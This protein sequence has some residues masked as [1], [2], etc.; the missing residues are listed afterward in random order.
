MHSRQLPHMLLLLIACSPLLYN[1]AAGE[2]D[3]LRHAQAPT[4]SPLYEHL[5]GQ[6]HEA[7]DRRLEEYESVE[8]A[9]DAAAYQ[10]KR[11]QFF[12]RQLG[13]FPQRTPLNPQVVGRFASNGYRVEKVIFESQPQHHVT[14]VMYLPEAAGLYPCVVVAS[15]HSR[16][17][18]AADYNQRF[19]IIM[20][21]NGMAALCYDPIGQGERSQILDDSGQPKHRSTTA[22]HFQIGVGSILLGTNTARYRVWDAM[23]A[24]DYAISRDD[25]DGQRIG[26]TGCSG[27]GTLTSYVMALDDRV[28]CAAPA[29]YLTTF[30]RLIDT[31][32]PQDAE[33]NIFGQIAFGMD[34]PDYVI[35]RAPRPTIISATTGDYFD[36]QGVW[37]NYRQ[38]KRF[39]MRLGHPERVDIVEG[40]GGHG[41]P[42]INLVTIARWMRRWLLERDDTLMPGEI[43]VHDLDTLRCTPTG[44]VL[45]LPGEL[46]VFQLNDLWQQQLAARRD[47]RWQRGTPENIPKKVREL[48]GIRVLDEL[49]R[50]EAKP[51]GRIQRDGY[52]IEK[53]LLADDQSPA[54]PALLFVPTQPPR[55]AYLY[56]HGEGKQADAERQGTIEQLVR[57]GHPVLA[58]DL[59]SLGETRGERADGP[60]GAWKDFYLAYLLGKSL[61]GIR[62]EAALQAGHWLATADLASLEIGTS[63]P[64][65]ATTAVRVVAKGE[66][67]VP[68][69]H[70]A[71]LSN[72]FSRVYLPGGPATWSDL[73]PLSET[74]NQLVSTVHGALRV[75]DL[76][77]LV[78]LHGDVRYKSPPDDQ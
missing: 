38:A 16:T 18:K 1:A 11:R 10:Q 15:G 25:I 28:R 12:L 40:P 74:D 31:I 30:R 35:L 78:E 3:V 33:Q 21:Q 36:I 23:R 27:G 22:E 29:C 72:C 7:L 43:A 67:V 37:S 14:A 66:A 73:V 58:V 64:T 69:L 51:V 59:P 53:L 75:Y 57:R 65:D 49:P 34:H 62:A 32:G 5:R 63:K 47:R 44:Q 19:G 50:L 77:N 71:A 56:L 45:D 61:V 52:H 70:A 8:T 24:I 20:A 76:P 9:A 13:E 48:A 54:L 17:A 26:F 42:M 60:M 4:R 39:Y 2:L 46:S 6:A 55:R 68:A 41:V